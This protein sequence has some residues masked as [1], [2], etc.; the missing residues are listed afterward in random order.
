[1]MEKG[2]IEQNLNVTPRICWGT[3]RSHC[4]FVGAS[5]GSSLGEAPTMPTTIASAAARSS[6]QEVSLGSARRETK[7]TTATLRRWHGSRHGVLPAGGG[8]LF[9]TVLSPRSWCTSKQ[10]PLFLHASAAPSRSYFVHIC[11][12]ESGTRRRCMQAAPP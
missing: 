10:S 4:N 11:T 9:A 8:H 3:Q 7:T 6:G 1:M 12:L 2:D 5:S